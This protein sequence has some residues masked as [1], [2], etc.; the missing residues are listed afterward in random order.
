MN[1][2]HTTQTR[3]KDGILHFLTREQMA[4]EIVRLDA[5][6][7]ATPGV[8]AAPLEGV[9]DPMD[10]PLPCDVTVG[11]GTMRKGVALRSLVLR[12]KSLYEMATGQNADEVANRTPAE[13]QALWDKSPLN[14]ENFRVGGRFTPKLTPEAEALSAQL[15]LHP[16]APASPQPLAPPPGEALTDEQIYHQARGNYEIAQIRRT[17]GTRECWPKFCALTPI[18]QAGWV[19]K[20]VAAAPQPPASVQPLAVGVEPA[21]VTLARA[22]DFL[23]WYI[24]FIKESVMSVDIERHP[25]L[26][27]LEDC[28]EQVRALSV[29]AA[30][31][32]PPGRVVPLTD[33]QPIET[34]PENRRVLARNALKFTAC[35]KKVRGKWE[36]IGHPTHWMEIPAF[37]LTSWQISGPK[38]PE[39]GIKEGS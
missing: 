37:T 24:A 25:Y 22:A 29:S 28:A 34:A 21:G 32:P 15:G 4:E 19:A 9:S 31:P 35:A 27:E 36:G 3:T 12:M 18:Q 1:T 7:A 33:W 23:E 17:K 2:Q 5:A 38:A 39:G 20:S 10:W 6:L 16:S 30:S 13:R 14:L 8:S 26:P 11:H